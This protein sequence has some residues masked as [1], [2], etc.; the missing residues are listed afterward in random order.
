MVLGN[1][2]IKDAFGGY[3]SQVE[4][5]FFS[6]GFDLKM[7]LQLASF[8]QVFWGLTSHNAFPIFLKVIWEFCFCVC[9]GWEGSLSNFLR[10]NRRPK[11]FTELFILALEN[12]SLGDLSF[13]FNN[14]VAMWKELSSGFRHHGISQN[15]TITRCFADNVIIFDAIFH[16]NS[17]NIL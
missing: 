14:T 15:I 16:G 9:F 13:C 3:D 17:L 10:G 6:F 2:C 12:Y 5:L 4:N 8:L 7:G 1:P 11:L